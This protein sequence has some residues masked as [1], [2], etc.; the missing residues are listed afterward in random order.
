MKDVLGRQETLSVQEAKKLLLKQVSGELKIEEVELHDAYFRVLAEDIISPEDLPGFPRSTV[1]GYAVKAEDTYGASETMPVLLSVKGEVVMGKVPEF[2]VGSGETAYVPT[3]GM[4]PEGTDSVVMIEDTNKLDETTIEVY[5][6]VAVG[7]NV[8]QAD[9][10]I[11]KSEPILYKNKRLRPQDIAALSAVG[12]SK[13]R[14]FAK[15]KVSIIA[16]GDEIV[17]VDAPKTRAQIRDVNSY[18]LVGMVLSEHCEPIRFGIIADDKELLY[19]TVYKATEQSDVVLITGGSSVGTRDF[20]RDV[21]ESLGEPGIL[22]HGVQMKPGK[23]LMAGLVKGKFIFGLPGHPV[24]VGICF[25]VF[26]RPLLRKLSGIV[27]NAA[28]PEKKITEAVLTTNVPSRFGRQE[29]VR[30]KLF[31]NNDTLFA[32]PIF[33][34]SAL[35][36]TLVDADGVIVVPKESNGFYE[37]QKVEVILF[38]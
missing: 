10:D 7:E 14:V 37:G 3:G 27:E 5:K 11:K 12:I 18:M 33:G 34:K 17:P 31:K 9:E 2:S 20:T 1:D 22:F 4:L 35:I 24:A 30:V 8:I 32:E 21:I 16:T 25:D 19:D 23:P 13:L 26:V 36:K 38:E 29:Y 28:V 15:P 6:A